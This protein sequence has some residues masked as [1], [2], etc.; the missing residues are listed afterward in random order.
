M[1]VRVEDRGLDQEHAGIHHQIRDHHQQAHEGA[2]DGHAPAEVVRAEDHREKVKAEECELLRNE[3]VD[4]RGR[5]EHQQ[6]ERLLEILEEI[7]LQRFHVRF[8][9]AKCNSA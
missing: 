5:D 9:Y 2:Q 7:S 4:D 3:E 1:S 6:N 8:V